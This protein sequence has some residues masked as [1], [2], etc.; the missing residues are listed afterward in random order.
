M[1][2]YQASAEPMRRPDHKSKK[3]SRPSKW[4]DRRKRMNEQARRWADTN[5]GFVVSQLALMV[6]IA[7][8]LFMAAD[9]LRYGGV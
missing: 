4:V 2:S 8:P 5:T 3:H 1:S 9:W 7:P 6:V